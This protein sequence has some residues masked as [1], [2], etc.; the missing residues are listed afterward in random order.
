MMLAKVLMDFNLLDSIH[1]WPQA[2]VVIVFTIV[3][4]AIIVFVFSDIGSHHDGE[5]K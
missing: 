4:G 2:V 5:E 1:S 3:I